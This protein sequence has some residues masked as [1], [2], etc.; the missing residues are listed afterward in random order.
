VSNALAQSWH[1]YRAL[2]RLPRELATLALMLLVSLTLLPVA[3]WFA[4]QVF[5]GEYIR[6]PS[7]AP[8]GG[9]GALWLDFLRGILSGSFGYWLA[10]LGPWLVLMAVRGIAALRRH[11][12]AQPAS[13]QRAPPRVP[14]KLT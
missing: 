7:G 9:F 4:G 14:P 13:P 6:D 2:P 12:R 1:R 5:L 10:F 11:E 3:I 8:V